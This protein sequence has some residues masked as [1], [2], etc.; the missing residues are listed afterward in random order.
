MLYADGN[1]LELK[2]K[3]PL[4]FKRNNRNLMII[5]VIYKALMCLAEKGLYYY[6]IK[7]ENILYKYIDNERR[8]IEIFLGD[9]GSLTESKNLDMFPSSLQTPYMRRI[10]N[11]EDGHK[12]YNSI[13]QKY[14]N[15]R[16]D[17]KIE[18][19]IGDNFYNKYPKLY[20]PWALSLLG[21][22]LNSYFNNYNKFCWYQL[23]EDNY[24]ADF[25]IFKD[26]MT[27]N[28]LLRF[29]KKY[30]EELIDAEYKNSVDDEWVQE[31]IN[32][33]DNELFSIANLN[34]NNLANIASSSI[35]S[36]SSSGSSGSSSGSS[37][38]S[39]SASSSGSSSGSSSASSASTNYWSSII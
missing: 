32:K 24:K 38:A 4:Y 28:N 7:P 13:N 14:E 16:F 19:K 6:D 9:L 35:S 15:I 3:F 26:K 30:V 17:E 2:Q 36:A 34:N 27:P 23:K 12:K 1:L 11:K 22:N 29:Y 20:Y 37:S 39:S 10:T 31:Y 33:F 25:N 21:L 8:E 18:I 5:H